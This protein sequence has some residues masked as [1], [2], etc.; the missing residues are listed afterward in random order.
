MQRLR[1]KLVGDQG[2]AIVEFVFVFC[3]IGVTILLFIVQSLMQIRHHL[4]ALAI[5]KETLRTSQLSSSEQDAMVAADE[6]A[7]IFGLDPIDTTVQSS[8]CIGGQTQV[9]VKVSG[10]EEIANGAC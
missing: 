3:V 7:A 10:A 8:Q 6:V 4:A 5:A 9:K 2:N 1:A